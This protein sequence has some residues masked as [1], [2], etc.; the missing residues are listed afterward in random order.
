MNYG[1]QAVCLSTAHG[2]ASIR[3]KVEEQSQSDV[4]ISATFLPFEPTRKRHRS[5]CSFSTTAVC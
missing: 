5:P 2:K 3:F 1:V 4:F